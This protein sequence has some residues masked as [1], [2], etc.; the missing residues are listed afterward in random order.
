[1]KED[2]ALETLEA[3]YL[4][5]QARMNYEDA[6]KKE[7]AAKEVQAVVRGS[8]ARMDQPGTVVEGK[9]VSTEYIEDVTEEDIKFL[10]GIY[11]VAYIVEAFVFW[12]FIEAHREGRETALMA[13]GIIWIVF[14]GGMIASTIYSFYLP[15]WFPTRAYEAGMPIGTEG[16]RV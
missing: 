9:N 14:L 15:R 6:V 1:M 11:V 16:G 12:A 5:E 3:L 2:Q 13:Y 7:R 10:T 4:G 8:S